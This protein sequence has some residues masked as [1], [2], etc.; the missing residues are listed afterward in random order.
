MHKKAWLNKRPLIFG[1][2]FWSVDGMGAVILEPVQSSG[3]ERVHGRRE[4]YI[5]EVI[6]KCWYLSVFQFSQ[7]VS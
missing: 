7:I 1:C 2:G 3:E 4:V 6:K 5:S